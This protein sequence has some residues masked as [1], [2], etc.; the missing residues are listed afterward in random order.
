MPAAGSDQ[1]ARLMVDTARAVLFA[2]DPVDVASGSPGC[3]LRCV[4]GH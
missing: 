3:F 1:A 2:Y 4:G